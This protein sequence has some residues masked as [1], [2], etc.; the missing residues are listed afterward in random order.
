MRQHFHRCFRRS[1]SG[2][3]H[4]ARFSRTGNNSAGQRCRSGKNGAGRNSSCRLPLSSHQ[5]VRAIAQ[6][7][8][9]AVLAGKTA[10]ADAARSPV[11]HI[12][13]QALGVGGACKGVDATQTEIAERVEERVERWR[14][15]PPRYDRQLPQLLTLR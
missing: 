8:H 1:P 5:S 9:E 15:R 10:P 7:G 4:E 2:A 13:G 11:A 14:H 12:S 3:T 6:G